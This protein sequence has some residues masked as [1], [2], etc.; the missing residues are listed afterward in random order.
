MGYGGTKTEMQRLLADA[1]KITGVKYN[2][3]KLADVYSAIHVIQGGV[4]ELNGGLGDVSKGLGITGTTAKEASTT[5]SGSMAAVKAAFSNVLGSLTIGQD[6]APA[7]EAL[8]ETMTTFV[9]GNLLPAV[10]NV[11]SALPGALVTFVRSL[12]PQ[13]TNA[14][15]AD[16]LPQIL[17]AISDFPQMMDTGAQLAV[18]LISN[19]GAGLQQEIPKLLSQ[20]LPML[21]DLSGVLRAN[22]GTIVD[23]GIDLILSLAQGLINGLPVMI[24]YIPQIISNLAGLINDNAPKI[25]EGGKQLIIMLG[26]GLI[27]AAPT[28]WANMGN[29]L[30]AAA[31]VITAI[32][33]LDL[34]SK[35][36]HALGS[37][38][39]AIKSGL[40]KAMESTFSEALQYIKGI[41][42]QAVE[43]GK[44]M[45]GGFVNGILGSIGNVI[46]AVKNVASAVA[47]Y[48]HFSRPDIGPLRN[49]EQWMPDM[50]DGL[51]EGIDTNRWRLESAAQLCAKAITDQMS[52]TSLRPGLVSLMQTQ[53]P[54][55]QALSPAIAASSGGNTFN[56]TIYTHDSLS[57]SEMTREA[58]AFLERCKWQIP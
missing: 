34:G 6:V 8:A 33:W 54:A 13:L 24:E 1:Q 55:W 31:D 23:V 10:W 47:S 5:I 18:S 3:D 52:V 14:L 11:L 27:Q 42:K 9:S 30:Q 26:K 36:I 48:L 38:F 19:F 32:N 50:I 20:A 39:I 46:N 2:I 57:A 51:V 58:Q 29:I 35:V 41:P 40:K 22:F 21:L 17:S 43:W 49:Y 25:L 53:I 28:L 4:D 56:Q 15:S 12:A 7:L 44:D 16:V 37:G 45:I